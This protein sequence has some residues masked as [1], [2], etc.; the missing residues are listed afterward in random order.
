[1]FYCVDQKE[2]KLLQTAA[3]RVLQLLS[4]MNVLPN[5]ESAATPSVSQNS[6]QGLYHFCP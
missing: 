5:L 6:C 2:L 3:P 1:M 4:E